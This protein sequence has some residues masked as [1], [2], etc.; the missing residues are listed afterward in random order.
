MTDLL[1]NLLCATLAFGSGIF[2]VLSLLEKPIWPLM[3]ARN[4]DTVTET[5]MRAVHAILKRVI[6]LLP[7]TMITTMAVSALLFIA[8]LI[9]E[10]FEM[11]M[12]LAALCFFVQQGLV[13]ARLAKDIAG[14]DSVDSQGEIDDVR[15]GLGALALL[16]HRGLLLTVSSLLMVLFAQA[17]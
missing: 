16:H 6:H 2:V 15:S 4:S 17:F 14:V 10:S 3:W 1:S 7:P 8:L 11:L 13:A 12:V 9:L 5:D